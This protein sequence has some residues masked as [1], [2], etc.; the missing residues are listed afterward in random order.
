[1]RLLNDLRQFDA[2]FWRYLAA[3]SLFSVGLFILAE[4]YPLYLQD[5]KVSVVMIGDASLAQNL[6]SMAGTIP[7]IFLMRTPGLKG[8][9]LLSL[10]GIGIASALKLW[11]TE[12]LMVY[13]GAFASG[14]F[15]AVL[16]VGIPV[17]VSRLTTPATRALGFSCFF[18]TTIASG[19]FGDVIGGELPYFIGDAFSVEKHGEQLFLASFLA[20]VLMLAAMVPVARMR[21]AE[22]D[23]RQALRVPRDA[24][25]VRLIVAMAAWSF[26]VGLFAPFYSL[27]FSVHL[28]QPVHTIGLDLAGGQVVG[29]VFTLFAPMFIAGWGAVRSVR[30][31]MFAAGTMA[32]FLSLVSSP[33]LVGVGYAVYMG[34]VA[35]VQTPLNTLL[36]NQVREEEQAGA[37]MINSLGGFSAVAAGGFIG[38]RLIDVLGFPPMLALSGAACMFAAVV[39]VVLVKPGSIPGDRPI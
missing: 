23:H 24:G 8:A 12:P 21:L 25:T 13:G 10:A 11:Y 36:M 32:F 20:C 35:M 29:A 18:V 17:T 5:Y 28:H 33:I 27:Y 15:L 34:Y 3:F 39:F 7:A 37:S 31:M 38:G 4:L 1:M 2:S 14:F 30:F 9:T 22:G 26:A 16:S 6:G 19:F